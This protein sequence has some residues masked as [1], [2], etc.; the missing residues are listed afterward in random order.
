MASSPLK[1]MQGIVTKYS[2][3]FR[4]ILFV[5]VTK[6][7]STLLKDFVTGDSDGRLPPLNFHSFASQ[8]S[9][10][11]R[12]CNHH[13]KQHADDEDGHQN[14]CCCC[15]AA[16]VDDKSEKE[17]AHQCY[18]YQYGYHQGTSHCLYTGYFGLKSL[19]VSNY[20]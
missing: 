9:W 12:H 11:R 3:L 17:Y 19:D 18:E 15:K 10:C 5:A 8:V 6:P 4:S 2:G 14:F 1:P 20:R 7:S 16:I 13:H